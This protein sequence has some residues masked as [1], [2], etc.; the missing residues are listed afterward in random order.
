MVKG[1]RESA[2]CDIDMQ[3]PTAIHL[4]LCCECPLLLIVPLSGAPALPCKSI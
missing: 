2:E 3:Q 1:G 4:C